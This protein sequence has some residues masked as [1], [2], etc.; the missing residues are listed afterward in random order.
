MKFLS[1][2]FWISSLVFT[3]NQILEASG[4]YLPFIHSYLDDFL[5][6]PIVLG[7]ALFIQ[8]QFTYR[9]RFYVLSA[10]M[11]AF[12]VIW[13]SLIFEVILP[14]SSE[15][16]HADPWDVLAYT[17]GGFL[18]YLKGNKPVNSLILKKAE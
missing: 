8:Q 11:I 5:C 9:N 16:F 2:L 6:P 12:F 17:L 3:T 18:F 15:Q 10:K 14:I 13:Y 1:P 4:I 7:F